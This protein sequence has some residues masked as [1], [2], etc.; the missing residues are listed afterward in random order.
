MPTTGRVEAQ[1]CYR[2]EKVAEACN[3]SVMCVP[4]QHA[5]VFLAVHET[6]HCGAQ[7]WDA[8][9]TAAVR[10]SLDCREVLVMVMRKHQRYFPVY[11]S[12]GSLMPAFVTVAN[13]AIDAQLVRLGERPPSYPANPRD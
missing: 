8:V 4:L 1:R 2:V 6:V 9:V 7:V 3:K 13:G 5:G 12:D 11:A 10:E